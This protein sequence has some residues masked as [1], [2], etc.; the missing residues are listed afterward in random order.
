MSTVL[1]KTQVIVRNGKPRA[2]I[3]DIK[4]YEFLLE[5]A[6]DREDLAELRRIKKGKTAFR[7][8]EDYLKIRAS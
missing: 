6:E 2:V 1:E 4:K 7:R 5:M 3:L 8:L